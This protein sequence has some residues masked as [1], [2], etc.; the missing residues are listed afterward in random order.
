M[1]RAGPLWP[2]C[3]G[4]AGQLYS[5]SVIFG[6][7][8]PIQDRCGILWYGPQDL[9]DKFVRGVSTWN[10][11]FQMFRQIYIY[12]LCWRMRSSETRIHV[13]KA[14]REVEIRFA[15]GAADLSGPLLDFGMMFFGANSEPAISS[16]QINRAEAETRNSIEIERSG[17]IRNPNPTMDVFQQS[18]NPTINWYPTIIDI[19]SNWYHFKIPLN[20]YIIGWFIFGSALCWAIPSCHGDGRTSDCWLSSWTIARW[21]ALGFQNVGDLLIYK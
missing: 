11:G 10:W 21:W 8:D 7:T 20:H 9:P 2:F 16:N 1:P 6:R 13:S 15:G 17:N 14:A 12:C 3:R 5:C 18:R 19:T 4:R